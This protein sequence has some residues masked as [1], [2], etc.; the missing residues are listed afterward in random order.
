[1]TRRRLNAGSLMG[2][3]LDYRAVKPTAECTRLASTRN[4]QPDETSSR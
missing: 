3:I 2:R 4:D 1:M